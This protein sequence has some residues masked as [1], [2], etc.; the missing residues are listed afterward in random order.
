M[1]PDW[2]QEVARERLR[3]EPIP[4]L[5]GHNRYTAHPGAISRAISEAITH[6]SQDRPDPQRDDSRQG[7]RRIVNLPETSPRLRSTVG[8]FSL[9]AQSAT[10]SGQS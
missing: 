6:H 7:L 5:G 8:R 9:E 3:T 4:V 1:Q 2:M 10:A